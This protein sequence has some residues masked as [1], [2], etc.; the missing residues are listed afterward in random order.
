MN[1]QNQYL[2]KRIHYCMANTDHELGEVIQLLYDEL[3]PADLQTIG[4]LG[5]VIDT[6]IVQKQV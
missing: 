2:G 6:N 3:K 4:Q 5:N 1:K